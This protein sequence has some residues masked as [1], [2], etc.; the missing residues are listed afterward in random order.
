[1]KKSGLSG[2]A[3][4][5]GSSRDEKG[6][7]DEVTGISMVQDQPRMQVKAQV[8]RMSWEASSGLVDKK[9]FEFPETES[10]VWTGGQHEG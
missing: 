6:G 9:V 4:V 3:T 1:M 7:Q 5:R 2:M 8:L 10:A